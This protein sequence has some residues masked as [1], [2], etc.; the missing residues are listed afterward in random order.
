[1]SISMSKKQAWS[2]KESTARTNLWVG[3]VRS[4]KTWASIFRWIRYLSDAPD[5]DLLMIGKTGRTIYRNVIRPMEDLLGSS[6]RYFPGKGEVHMFDRR[7]FIV[8]ANDERAEGI[9]RGMTCAGAYGDEPTLWPESFFNQLL[10]RVSVKNSKIF[11][12]TNTD[13][14]YH[15]LKKKFV[16]RVDEL[17]LKVFEFKI[18]DNP[19]LDQEY[20]AA[21]KKEYVGLWY[22]RFISGLWTLAE[23]AIYDFY[24]EDLHVIPDK[25]FPRPQFTV[26]GV[27]YGTSNPTVFIEYGVNYNTKPKIWAIKEWYYDASGERIQLTD[28]EYAEEFEEWLEH[29]R[30]RAIIID[31]SAASFRVALRKRGY[32]Q[33][34]EADND[35]TGGIRLVAKMLKSGDYKIGE[36]CQN[37]REERPGYSW[38][39]KAQLRGLDEPIKKDD[40]C[41]DNERYVIKTLFD[42]DNLVETTRGP[43]GV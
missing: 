25:M 5:G 40:H 11:A 43:F 4:G 41:M 27:D 21:L 33:V 18:D 3:S 2:Y 36:S 35:V 20:V 14:P 42:E 6:M 39:P 1:M 37:L 28:D 24:N 34:E 31:P 38:D 22:D 12:A 26:V 23:G 17:N 19:F 29:D 8:G 13:S 7:I 9:I 30:P 15:Y 16:D 32:G 10:S